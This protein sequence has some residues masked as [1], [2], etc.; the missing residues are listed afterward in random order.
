MCRQCSLGMKRGKSEGIGSVK[1][2]TGRF[3]FEN[4]GHPS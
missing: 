1:A 3:R 2:S 4:D